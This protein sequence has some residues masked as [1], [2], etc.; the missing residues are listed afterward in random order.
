MNDHRRRLAVLAAMMC[1]SALVWAQEPTPSGQLAGLDLESLFGTKVI[2]AS[3][4]PQ[5][6]SDAPGILSVVSNDELRRFG[7]M[8]LREILERVAGLTGSSSYF[9][10]RSLVSARGDQAKINGGHILFLINGRP[11][12]EIL[13]GGLIS[14]LLE[15]FPVRILERIEV[16]KGPGSVL[17]GSNAFSAVVNL[18][19]RK[20]DADRLDVSTYGS[21]M[22]GKG[23]SGEA[24]FKRGDFSMT[25]AGQFRQ[26]PGWNTSYRFPP[27][28]IGALGSPVV[29]ALQMERLEDRGDGAYLGANYKGL[30]LMSSYT[31]WRDPSFVRGTV[32]RDVWQRGFAD[33]G[34]DWKARSNWDMTVNATYTRNKFEVAGYPF[35]RRDSREVLVEWTNFVKISTKDRV[36]FGTLFNQ[37]AGQELYYGV[38]PV[39]VISDGS[40]KGGALYAQLEHQ[41]T[42]SV[43]LIGG[44]QSNKTAGIGMHTVPRAGLIWNPAAHISV[45]ALYSGAFRAPSINETLLNHPGLE[46]NPN[47][48]P[49]SVST[50]DV[51]IAYSGERLEA[52]INYFHSA[53]SDSIGV[54]IRPAP[55]RWIYENLGE[56]RFQG[57]EFESKYYVTKRLF[58]TGSLQYQFN[59]NQ[60]D[61]PNVTP[62]P[63]WGGKAGISYMVDKRLTASLFDVAEGGMHGWTGTL[64]PAPNAYH[65]LNAHL[66]YQLPERL[67]PGGWPVMAIFAHA[68]NLANLQVWLPDWGGNSNSTIPVD[69]GRTIF[70]GVEFAL[71]RD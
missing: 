47:L 64:N 68:E 30:S 37:Q 41:L 26:E 8:T 45:K 32:G 28:L 20:A 70:L 71:K 46:G 67:H 61:T 35:V 9:T 62:V 18:I 14:D 3:K 7:G 19:T 11:T 54:V 39:A 55:L 53:Q 44:F 42:G 38:T 23:A 48:R 33:L 1:L 4:F 49:E 50:I 52:G 40:R 10:D 66:R 59:E 15:S 51:G 2:T 69:R 60:A 22:G 16:I 21:E 65:L 57:G 27:D 29:P 6:L 43:K 63:N 5:K 25:G 58:L 31:E 24:M 36:T 34:Y 17:Y 12:R 56:T 13:E